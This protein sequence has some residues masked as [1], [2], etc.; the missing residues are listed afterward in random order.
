MTDSQIT[1]NDGAGRYELHVDGELAA[2]ADFLAS[3]GRIVFT[4]TETV[5]AFSGQGRGTELVTGAVADSVERG[6]TIVPRCPFVRRYL[7]RNDIPGA[8]VEYPN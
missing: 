6:D 4:H 3:D 2:F 5:E 7:E 8:S 1:R